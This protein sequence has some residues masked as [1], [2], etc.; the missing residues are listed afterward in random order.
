M[1]R[2]PCLPELG[3][4]AVAVHVGQ[5]VDAHYISLLKPVSGLPGCDSSVCVVFRCSSRMALLWVP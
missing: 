4:A 1:L 5:Q 3:L 2:L